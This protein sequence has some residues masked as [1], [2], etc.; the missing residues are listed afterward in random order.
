LDYVTSPA[1]YDFAYFDVS[2]VRVFSEMGKNTVVTT[3]STDGLAGVR[4][5][6]LLIAGFLMA[7][8]MM[9]VGFR[10]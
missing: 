4:R 2:Y 9:S 10:L 7:F 8:I 1:N 6:W 3:N 5:V